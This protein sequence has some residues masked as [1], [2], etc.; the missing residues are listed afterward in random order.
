VLIDVDGVRRRR[1]IA[2]GIQRLLRSMKEHPHYTPADS[3]AL[4]RGYAPHA[5]FVREG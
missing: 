2:L 1:W 4:C 5:K 3:L